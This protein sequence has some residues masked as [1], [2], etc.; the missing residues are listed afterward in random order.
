MRTSLLDMAAHA[1]ELVKEADKLQAGELGEDEDEDE[2][3]EGAEE[4]ENE[5]E[6]ED[7]EVAAEKDEN[8]EGQDVEAE[9]Q[10]KEDAEDEEDEEDQDEDEHE[11]EEE[12]EEEEDEDAEDEED[13]EHA[14]DEESHEQNSDDKTPVALVGESVSQDEEEDFASSWSKKKEVLD[15]HNVY[16]CMHGVPLF[17]W[18]DAMARNAQKYADRQRGQ[19]SHSPRS[20]RTPGTGFSSVGENLA[21]GSSP[22]M[23]TGAQGVK[24]WYDEIKYTRG[25]RAR[26]MNDGTGVIG[27]YTQVV[28]KAS[29]ELGCGAAAGMLVCMYGP[30]GNLM[31]AFEQNVN[32]PKKSESACKGAGGGG[33]G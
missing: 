19:M 8:K 9:E 20:S 30:A 22:D 24:Q 6:D 2:D 32:G 25:G 23:M 28:W 1:R 4:D 21:W 29:V 33:G 5:E 10:E 3:K 14:E 7:E 13:G 18:N 31:G 16:R 17:K 26:N 12:E 15:K 11:E 27:H